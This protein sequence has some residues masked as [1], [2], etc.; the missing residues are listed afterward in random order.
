MS[1]S[2]FIKWENSRISTGFCFVESLLTRSKVLTWQERELWVSFWESIL[3]MSRVARFTL[4]S[5]LCFSITYTTFISKCSQFCTCGSFANANL[6]R[7]GCIWNALKWKSLASFSLISGLQFLN[8]IVR[9][10]LRTTIR[11]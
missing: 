4:E 9:S 5:K 2:G 8:L 7:M 10:S 11:I 1:W 3:Q 6:G